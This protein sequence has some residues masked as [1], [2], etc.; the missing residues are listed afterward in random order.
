MKIN[1]SNLFI[2]SDLNVKIQCL[3][4][5]E[6]DYTLQRILDA[7]NLMDEIERAV[8]N[9]QEVYYD[10]LIKNSKSYDPQND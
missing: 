9:E 7:L 4:K 10:L 6:A 1:L 5:D 8:N 3:E 2:D